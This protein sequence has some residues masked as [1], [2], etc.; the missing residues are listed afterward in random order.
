MTLVIGASKI[1]DAGSPTMSDETIGSS[2]YRRMP[3]NLGDSAAALTMALT[4]ST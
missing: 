3:W 2:L 4:S 1:E